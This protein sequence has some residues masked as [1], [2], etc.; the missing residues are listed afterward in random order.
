M[1]EP[2]PAST[3]EVNGVLHAKATL[4]VLP[5]T[6]ADWLHMSLTPRPHGF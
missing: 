3:T 1:P 2:P 4:C 5:A 6:R